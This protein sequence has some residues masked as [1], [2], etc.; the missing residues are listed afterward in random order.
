MK[1]ALKLLLRD[2]RSGELNILLFSIILA[3]ATITSISL[4]TSRLENSIGSEAAVFFAGDARIQSSQPFEP[5]WIEQAEQAQLR[6]S[7]AV[8]FRAMAFAGD[9]MQLSAVKAVSSTYPLKGELQVSQQA[10]GEATALRNGPAPGEV[11]LASRLFSGLQIQVGDTINIGE[12]S[13]TVSQAIIREP[14]D[15]QSFFGV[16]PRALIHSDDVVKTGAVQTGS[17]VN[18]S[19]MLAGKEKD[20]EQYH[21]WLKEKLGE[22]ANWAEAKT[23]NQSIGSA[24]QRA[25]KFLLLAGSLSVVLCGLAIALAA[26]RYAQRHVAQVALLKTFGLNPR[27][28]A[29]FYLI[30]LLIVGALCIA[31]GVAAGQ[32]LQQVIITSL[33]DLMPKTLSAPSSSAYF[34]GVVSGLTSLIA[35]AAPPLFSLRLVPPIKILQQ[36]A[37]S[38]LL[39]ARSAFTIGFFAIV[40]LVYWFAQDLQLTGILF[41]ASALCLLCVSLLSWLLIKFT[42]SLGPQFGPSLRLGIANLYRHRAFNVVQIMIFATLMM[43]MYILILVRTSI[44]DQWRDTLPDNAPNH[45]IFNIFNHELEETQQLFAASNIEAQPFY[46]M[47]RGRVIDI[48]GTEVKDIVKNTESNMNY[49]RE[50]NLT[51][52]TSLGEDNKVVAGSWHGESPPVTDDNLLEVSAEKEYAEGLKLEVGDT[53]TFSVAGSTFPASL[54]SIRSVEWDSMN[55][56][57]FMVF[58]RPVLDNTATNWLTSAY[59]APDQKLF[60]NKLAQK[61]PTISIIE[62]DQMIGQLRRII[63]QISQAIEFILILVLSSGTLVFVTCIQSTLDIRFHESAI[64]RTLGAKR[65][66]VRNQLLVEY[67][68]LGG[69]SG[70]IAAVGTETCLFFLQTYVFELGFQFH[71]SLWLTAI[72]LGVFSVGLVGW[73]SSRAVVN[74]PPLAILRNL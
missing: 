22:H 55:P 65:A 27:D 16:A 72:P 7:R 13:F 28:I 19:L 30:Q 52:A 41:A 12:A 36:A 60:I 61:F 33:G 44:I 69:L 29:Q 63:Q 71:W 32:L 51:W 3:T 21:L 42:Q 31:V 70:L 46:P 14:D 38:Q 10:F 24:L 35:F 47:L 1:L 57:F 5:S 25:E 17:R 56:N 54:T 43:L 62:V 64:L 26:R 18:Y 6:H 53:I 40:L 23:A 11:W 45:F 9:K 58:N 59:L 68:T 20:L 39:A 49:R 4:F 34:V 73:L 66:L 2:W 74:T 67:C 48:N 8:S 15:T 50:L 37:H